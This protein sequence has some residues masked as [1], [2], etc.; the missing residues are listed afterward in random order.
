MIAI[1]ALSAAG[2]SADSDSSATTRSSATG[3]GGASSGKGAGGATGGGTA[4]GGRGGSGGVGGA[5]GGA[6]GTG[7]SGATGGGGAGAAGGAGGSGGTTGGAAGAAGGTVDAG[8]SDAGSGATF[9]IPIGPVTLAPGEERV[10]CIDK[11]I[12]ANRPV[13]LVKIASELTKGGHHL[14]FYKSSATVE[15]TTPFTCESF[16]DI[17]VGTVPLF[18]AQKSAT[19]LSFPA[20]VAYTMPANQM[21]RVELHFL[22][23]TPAP[24]PITGKVRLT[25]AKAG[26]I[27][28][29]ANLMFYGNLGIFLPPH[30]MSTV[31]PTFRAVPA[32]RKIFGLTGHQH[33]LGTGVTI[34]LA[35]DAFAAGTQI[36][37]N[38]DWADPPLTI[39]NPPL[40][41]AAGHGLRYV[42]N[43]NNTTPN[44]VTFGEGV[45][46]EMCFLW[47]YYYPD[48]GFDI[49]F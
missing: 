11:K 25:E 2:C 28:E 3:A 17:L 29:H 48:Q 12:P 21:V 22:N 1:A 10:V 33:H 40:T 34:E 47:A 31:G 46:Q 9:E 5:A 35:Q 26:T 24:L 42:C 18:I 32:G 44:I 7:G 16:R 30:A 14:V 37:K 4:T 39:F 13:D 45:N 23:S 8:G 15:N 43:Y 49:G 36:Y 41:P 6:G 27:S 19:E 20:G 38:L